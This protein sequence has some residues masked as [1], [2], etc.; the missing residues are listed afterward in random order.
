MATKQRLGKCMIDKWI[1]NDLWKVKS[2]QSA[3]HMWKLIDALPDVLGSPSWKTQSLL[4]IEEGKEVKYLFY[5]CI[6]LDC[7]RLLLRHLLFKKTLFGQQF[8]SI[9]TQLI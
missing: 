1:K 3:D 4:M 2:F 8:A 7:V 9:Q 5:Y 6:A